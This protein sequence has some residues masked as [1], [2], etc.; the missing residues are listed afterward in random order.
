MTQ[1]TV[2]NNKVSCGTETARDAILAGDI[3]DSHIDIDVTVLW[4]VC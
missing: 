1:P 4:S 3:A 2:S